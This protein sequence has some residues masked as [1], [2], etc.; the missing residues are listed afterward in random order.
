MMLLFI[1]ILVVIR[2]RLFCRR[3]LPGEPSFKSLVNV[4]TVEL[5]TEVR[6]SAYPY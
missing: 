2:D 1:F 4:V 3:Y 6:L 5:S